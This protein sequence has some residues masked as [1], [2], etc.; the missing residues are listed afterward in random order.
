MTRTVLVM[1]GAFAI[2]ASAANFSGKW[3][4]QVPDR[5]PQMREVILV[6]NQVGSEVTGYLPAG[7]GRSSGSPGHS[8]IWEGKAE[9][10]TISFYMWAGRDQVAK[11]IYKGKMVGEQITF[12]VTGSAPSYNFRGELNPPA[13]PRQVTAKRAR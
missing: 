9:G 8:E 13:A 4:L 3:A 11:I 5:G 7:P 10:D 2:T 6:L 1:M 12:T